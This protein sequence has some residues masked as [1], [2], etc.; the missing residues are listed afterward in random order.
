MYNDL[1]HGQMK[2]LGEDLEVQQAS[3]PTDIIWENREYSPETR[4]IKA[5][6]VWVF[7]GLMLFGSFSIIFKF[8][9]AANNAKFM[10]P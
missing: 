4:A 5:N 8:T 9:V 1:P 6:V 3:E 7:I 10:F 2:F